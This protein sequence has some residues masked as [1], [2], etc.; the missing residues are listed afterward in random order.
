MPLSLV[1]AGLVLYVARGDHQHDGARGAGD[2]ARR[3]RRRRHRRRGEHRPPAPTGP[4]GGL[5]AVDRVDHPRRRR[6]RCGAPSSTPRSSRSSRCIPIFFLQQPHGIV[7][8]AARRRPM[9][10]RCMVSLLVALISTP[11]LSLILYSRGK[12][13]RHESPVAKRLQQRLRADPRARSCAARRPRTACWPSLAVLGIAI[14]PRLGESLFPTFKEQDFLM[15]WLTK[16]GTSLPEEQRIVERGQPGAAGHPG[17]AELR[18]AHRPGAARRGDRPASTSAR[19]GSASTRRPTTTRR[20]PRS[21][22]PSS[23]TRACSPT[24]RPTSPSA[25]A[26]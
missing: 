7:L 23:S 5:H 24:S 18:L 21:R 22:R 15:H 19:T 4:A 2:R 10:S 26:R 16:P 17:R 14:V 8:Q 1:A 12:V 13:E 25:S 20:G 3:D 11:A 6:S 9:R